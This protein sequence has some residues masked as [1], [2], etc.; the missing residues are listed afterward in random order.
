MKRLEKK[1]GVKVLFALTVTKIN[2]G[3]IFKNSN[4][5]KKKV[6]MLRKKA[7]NI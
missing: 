5:M 7:E 4:S 6:I 1:L 2:D 3:T